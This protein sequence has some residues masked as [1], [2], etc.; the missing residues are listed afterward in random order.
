[1]YCKT[2]FLFDDTTLASDN[3]SHFRKNL[4]ERI[5]NKETAKISALSSGKTDKFELLTGEEISPSDQ[6]RIVGHGRFTGSPLDKA[7][8]K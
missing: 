6:S 4:L 7:F 2:I 3:S 1:M 5:F 8:E